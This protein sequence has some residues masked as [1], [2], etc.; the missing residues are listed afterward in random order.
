[1]SSV[2]DLDKNEVRILLSGLHNLA[3]DSDLLEYLSSF[4]NKARFTIEKLIYKFEDTFKGD[5][6]VTNYK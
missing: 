3:I 6:N 2:V 4:D 5:K 1:M